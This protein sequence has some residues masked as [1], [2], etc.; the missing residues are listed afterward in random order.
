MSE[1]VN[2]LLST[3]NGEKYLSELLTSLV[4][5]SYP[6][7]KITIRD[8][9]SSDNTI[10]IIEK[11]TEGRNNIRFIRGQNLGVI[12]SFFTL[13]KEAEYSGYYAFCDQDDVWD[14]CKIS[15]A[16]DFLK[17]VSRDV[18]ALYCSSYVL[19]DEKL[20]VLSYPKSRR[21]NL[22]FKNAL[23]ENRITGCTAVINNAARNLIIKELP[24]S[25]LMHDWWIYLVISAF[26]EIFFD[27]IPGIL[28]RQHSS[29]VVGVQHDLFGKWKSRFDRFKTNKNQRLISKQAEDFR[30]IFGLS[31]SPENKKILDCFINYQNSFLN[32]I[33]YSLNGKTFRQSTIDNII[34]K[35]L[36]IMKQV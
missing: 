10:N 14:T 33:I 11:F 12:K 31:L 29:N 30:R 26:G 27:N 36:Y 2:I 21:V 18:P 32:R 20:N 22:S 25:A 35:F 13:L 24:N 28:Y 7:L 8:D 4:N 19:V 15:Y 34:F 17:T 16:I 23:I 5:Q 3:Y 6:Y 1:Q 9:G